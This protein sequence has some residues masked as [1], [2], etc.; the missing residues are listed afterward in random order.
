MCYLSIYKIEHL[1]EFKKT[2]TFQSRKKT[3]PLLSHMNDNMTVND[4][5]LV[6]SLLEFH[7]NNF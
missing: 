4:L 1:N 5:Y 2:L 7:I 6:N 3:I